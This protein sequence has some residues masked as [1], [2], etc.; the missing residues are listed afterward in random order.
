MCCSHM[1]WFERKWVK[2]LPTK[3]VNS[4]IILSTLLISDTSEWWPDYNTL[5]IKARQDYKIIFSTV[6][7]KKN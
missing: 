3:V 2:P 4:F 1:K 6:S 5:E 7:I